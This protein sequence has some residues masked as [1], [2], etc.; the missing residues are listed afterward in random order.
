MGKGQRPR[1]QGRRVKMVIGVKDLRTTQEMCK[2]KPRMKLESQEK[3]ES[4]MES[5]KVRH[6]W[7]RSFLRRVSLDMGEKETPKKRSAS[8]NMSLWGGQQAVRGVRLVYLSVP[9]P[10]VGMPILLWADCQVGLPRKGSPASFLA[11]LP[12]F[13]TDIYTSLTSHTA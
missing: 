8:F 9:N 7:W 3:L 4:Q 2:L 12:L 1:D 5:Q 10:P 11:C 13:E 6:Q